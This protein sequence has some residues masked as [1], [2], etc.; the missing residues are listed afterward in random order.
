MI[1]RKTCDGKTVND[2]EKALW[3]CTSAESFKFQFNLWN[4]D[5]NNST[6]IDKKHFK[7]MQN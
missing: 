5:L 3:K 1:Q 4:F 2:T 7:M 6:I